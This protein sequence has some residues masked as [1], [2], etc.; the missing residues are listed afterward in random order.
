ME[1][2]NFTTNYLALESP[3]FDQISM[4]IHGPQYFFPEKKLLSKIKVDLK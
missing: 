1:F 2:G 4:F 3:F